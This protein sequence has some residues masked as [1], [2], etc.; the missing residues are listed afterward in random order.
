MCQR[1][2]TKNQ[3]CVRTSAS[4]YTSRLSSGNFPIH[5]KRPLTITAVRPSTLCTIPPQVEGFPKLQVF[6]ACIGCVR[7]MEEVQMCILSVMTDV[8][9]TYVKSRKILTI[10]GGLTFERNV[11][12]WGSMGLSSHWQW[13]IGQSHGHLLTRSYR[14]SCESHFGRRIGC[15][16]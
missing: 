15:A 8:T 11:W 3:T 1:P 13:L 10:E 12:I 9:G 5:S 16:S 4:N 2:E 14:V 7:S 6:G